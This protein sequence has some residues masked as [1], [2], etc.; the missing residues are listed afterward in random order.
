MDRSA[1][2]SGSQPESLAV[3]CIKGVEDL[4]LIQKGVR[5]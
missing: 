5:V 3:V 2:F 4:G 1:V